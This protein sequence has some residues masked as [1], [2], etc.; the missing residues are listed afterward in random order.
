MAETI[1]YPSDEFDETRDVEDIPEV[2]D[3]MERNLERRIDD[4]TDEPPGEEDPELAA[5]EEFEREQG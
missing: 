5:L 1:E 2:D 4:P 3:D